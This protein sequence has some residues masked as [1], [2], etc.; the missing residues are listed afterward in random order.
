[1]LRP[2]A[3]DDWQT[4]Q[5]GFLFSIRE[6][7]AWIEGYTCRRRFG[8]PQSACSSSFWPSW[9][10]STAVSTSPPGPVSPS[11]ADLRLPSAR[12]LRLLMVSQIIVLGESLLTSCL[13]GPSSIPPQV[14]LP[15]SLKQLLIMFM[16]K[17]LIS[18]PRTN[19]HH[20]TS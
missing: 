15:Q 4:W 6:K 12:A 9:S 8:I 3:E 17:G 20:S 2:R 19:Y 11:L 10:V 1:M 7:V 18:S 13:D 14:S 16:C 5:S